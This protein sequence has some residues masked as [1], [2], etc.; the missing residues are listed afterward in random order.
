[1]L[2]I[3]RIDYANV[4][5]IFH[6][7][8]EHF[9]CDGYRFTAGVPARLN[10]LLAAGE[11]DVCPSSSIEYALRAERYLIIPGLSISSIGAVA[12][13]LLFSH[14]PIEELDGCEIMLSAESATSVNLLRI[15]MAKRFGCACRY[16]VSNV[17]PAEAL[18]SAPAM[19]L[20]GDAALRTSMA[21]TGLRVYDLG[22]L[23]HEWTGLPFVFA[24]WFCTRTAA[25]ERRQEV[26]KLAEE[27][28][29]AKQYAERE[30][31][32]IARVSP[33]AA[34]MGFERLMAYWRE[35]ISYELGGGEQNGLRLFYR[36]A[37]ELE[38]I[39]TAPELCFFE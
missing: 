22:T 8:R 36:Y 11:I 14:V 21:G 37:A 28:V 6:A 9:S 20:I 12:S 29:L 5:P 1:M 23:W 3:G 25:R 33:E 18:G 7:L 38:L 35:N 27:L 4:T 26:R 31:E 2:T 34:W 10:S 30:R 19:L 24:L 32:H 15:L 39:P 13:V 16:A 17:A